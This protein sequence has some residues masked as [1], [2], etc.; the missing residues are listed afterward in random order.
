MIGAVVRG[1][2]AE[3]RLV[4]FEH[5]ALSILEH[6]GLPVP[7]HRFLPLGAEGGADCAKGFEGQPTVLKVVSPAI[8]HKSD[9]GGLAF[10]SR[11]D[12]RG[13]ADQAARILDRLKGPLRD[14]VRGFLLEERLD[15][16]PGLG[17]ELLLGM[18]RSDEFG[19]IVTLG[20][21]GTGVEALDAAMRPGQA[22]ILF[23]PVL[24]RPERLRE[25]LGQALF[26]R[27]VA[28][29]V[30][31]VAGVTSQDHLIEEMRRWLGALCHLCDAAE[32]EGLTVAEVEFNPLVWCRGRWMPVDALV[33]L[34]P[35]GEPE[36]E[37][38]LDHVRRLL[39]PRSVCVVGASPKGMNIGRIILRCALD[40]GFPRERLWV[41]RDDVEE[42]DGTRAYRSVSDLPEPVDLLVVAVSAPQ[43]PAL[44][45]EAFEA[46]KARGV[47]LIP[48]G[49]GET[50]GGK[51]IAAQVQALLKRH[52][53]PDRPV[54]L[55]N[56]SLGLVS[57]PDRFDSLFIP[58]EKLPRLSGGVRNVALIS[59]SG[60]Y[61]ITRISKMDFLSPDYQVSVG[62]QM[63]A[64]I[65]HVLE[66][67]EEDPRITTFALYVEGFRHRDGER[68]AWV[69][70]RI[71]G[72]GR[73]VVIYKAG[74]NPLGQAASAGHTASL[75]GDYRVFEE[76][77]A[78]V[79]AL[80][81]RTF[82]EFVQMIK[83]SATLHNRQFLGRRAAFLSNA[84]YETVGMADNHRGP[85]YVLEPASLAPET[86]ERIRAILERARL[87]GLVNIANPLDITPMANDAVHEDLARALLDDPGVD[88]AVFGNVPLTP[89]I[90]SLPHGLSP[91]DVFDAEHGY[92][93]RMMRL[94]SETRKPFVVVLDSGRHYDDM[95]YFMAHAGLPVFRSADQATAVLGKYVENR[96]GRSPA[97]DLSPSP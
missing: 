82:T 25:K 93:R 6:L 46:K 21:G 54:I 66:V 80:V 37:V 55:G 3:G 62:N 97:A 71:V 17:R 76:V 92:A 22:T 87:S 95:F 47:L 52:A 8:L 18:R 32:A 58:R 39:H 75:A 44:L 56:N 26:A 78:D 16:E 86:V 67:L 42:I 77:M 12:A 14:S 36:D 63:D 91:A 50:E 28:G 59:Q 23:H 51:G 15:Y 27:W 40:A 45:A 96:L 1:A 7:R 94:F 88:V 19:D 57:R 64:R 4:L 84:G 69:V 83:V 85:D 9:V 60:A 29:E 90:Q 79:G 13:V 41:I 48:G 74:R 35:R 53:G 49:M 43:V 34:A 30:R 73:D 70:R 5:E 20:F 81:A 33:R 2:V 65:S 31:G 24:T 72:G 11:T 38:P 89:N 61:M 68:L 10:L